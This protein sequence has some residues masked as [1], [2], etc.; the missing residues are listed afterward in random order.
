M[1]IEELLTK[2]EK[3]LIADTI[4]WMLEGGE[5]RPVVLM[6]LALYALDF[7]AHDAERQV[8][9]LASEEPPPPPEKDELFEDAAAVVAQRPKGSVFSHHT[10][11]RFMGIPYTKAAI[12]IDQ[13]ETYGLISRKD[14]TRSRKVL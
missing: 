12:L 1:K 9:A 3:N 6:G 11:I 4:D 8:A 13:L 10:L 14:G 7:I 2:K 5:V